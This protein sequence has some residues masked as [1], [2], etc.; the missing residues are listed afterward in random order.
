MACLCV[1]TR[2]AMRQTTLRSLFGFKDNVVERACNGSLEVYDLFCG[3]GGFS[4]GAVAAGCILTSGI[5][6]I[7]EL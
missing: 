2:Q 5:V 6:R 1:E 4:T 3:A 7:Y